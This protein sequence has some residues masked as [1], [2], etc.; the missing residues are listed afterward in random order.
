MVWQTDR[1]TNT[2]TISWRLTHSFTRRRPSQYILLYAKK[3]VGFC[4][5][6]FLLRP[7]IHLFSQSVTHSPVSSRACHFSCAE[8]W[9]WV[10]VGGGGD[11]VAVAIVVAQE[12][13]LVVVFVVLHHFIRKS[14]K[15]LIFVT[16]HVF[17][18]LFLSSLPQFWVAATAP[19]LGGAWGCFWLV[20][21]EDDDDVCCFLLPVILPFFPLPFLVNLCSFSTCHVLVTR[22]RLLF[23][24]SLL[25]VWTLLQWR[26]F[27]VCVGILYR[28]RWG[29][30]S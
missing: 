1:Q 13:V 22:G 8:W 27:L 7:S 5:L 11:G 25:L 24:I 6:G 19:Q 15:S 20:L 2:H 18:L 21:D 3:I 9:W 26:S 30:F 28:T 10:A 12:C 16:P 17:F 4:S 23:L 29:T 14:F